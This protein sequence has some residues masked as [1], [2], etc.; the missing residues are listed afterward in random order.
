MQ[1]IPE[2]TK[3]QTILA[4][5]TKDQLRFVVALQ[6]HKTK[7]AAAKALKLKP[8]TVYHWDNELIEEATRLMAMD[9]AQAAM[10]LRRRNLIKAMGVKAAGLDSKIEQ[11]RQ[12]VATEIIEGELGKPKEQLD[13]TSGGK[14]L[15]APKGIDDTQFDRAIETLANALREIVPGAGGE[16]NG[17]VDTPK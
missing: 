17:K 16:Q 5:L 11:V 8:D 6:E 4:Q 2:K 15:P 9:I 3:L 13:L 1:E 12:K 14:E 10:E 7:D